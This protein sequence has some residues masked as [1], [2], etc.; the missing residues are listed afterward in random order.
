MHTFT[1]S[2]HTTVYTHAIHA[3]SLHEK[4]TKIRTCT[5]THHTQAMEGRSWR[6]GDDNKFSM[7]GGMQDAGTAASAQLAE[8]VAQ[9]MLRRHTLVA[10]ANSQQ[11]A[12]SLAGLYLCVTE[13][14]VVCKCMTG[15]VFIPLYATC[16]CV[17]VCACFHSHSM[18]ICLFI[19]AFSS[20]RDG[21]GCTT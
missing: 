3:I 13:R 20:S 16:L 6:H 1:S 5:C 15:S 10:N 7:D 19:Y 21:H 8:E 4:L 14:E 9:G 11:Q 12:L 18:L 2:K 17:Y